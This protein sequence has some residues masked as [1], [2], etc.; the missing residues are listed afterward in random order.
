MIPY[1]DI[2]AVF[3]D[4][5]GTLVG[6]DFNWISEELG[7][8]GVTCTADELARAEA[9]A[10]PAVSA[11]LGGDDPPEEFFGFFLSSMLRSALPSTQHETVSDLIVQLTPILLPGGKGLKL[12]SAILSGTREVLIEFSRLGLRMAV[13]SNSDGTLAESLKALDLFRFFN[14][15]ID[16][17]IVGY[18]KPDS[19]IF[20]VALRAVGAKA[21]QTVHIG[22]MYFADVVGARAAGLHPVLLDP[23]G[24][25]GEVDCVRVA[26]LAELSAKIQESRSLKK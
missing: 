25:W 2:D 9:A 4:L 8:L 18:A 22:D 6:I 17:E 21:G 11:R 24:D 13:V 5:G 15:V 3:F 23:Y 7:R 19:R 1:D 16:S 14:A 26:S 10:R 12:W 20:E